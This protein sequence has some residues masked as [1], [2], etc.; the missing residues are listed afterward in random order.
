M[1]EQNLA[2]RTDVEIAVDGVNVTRKLRPYFL[3]L[4]YTDCEDGEADDLQL[5]LQDREGLWTGGWLDSMIQAAAS[6]KGLKLKAALVQRDWTGWGDRWL[7][8]GTFDLDSVEVS[9]PP[10]LVLLKATALPFS[11][12]IRQ[13]QKSRAWE[14]CSLSAIA[15]EMARAAGLGCLYDAKTDPK[16][17]RQEQRR[18]SDI[19]FLSRLCRD[20]GLSLKAT[21]GKLVVFDQSVYEKKPPVRTIR[22]GR[23]YIRCQLATGTA[24][25]QYASCRVR[26]T[27]PSTGRSIEGVAR[28]E[29][30][31]GEAKNNQQLEVS[32]KVSSQGQA[33]ALAASRLR[34]HNTFSRT[35]SFVFPG[36]PV[37]LAG[38]T[39]ELE[40]WG[41][42]D[43]KYMIAQAVH[44]VDGD[45]YTTKIELRRCLG[46]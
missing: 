46:S 30:Y 11:G 24:G 14:N 2:R 20:A 15:R 22:R 43:G 37:L 26:Y 1:T 3:S 45:G 16:Y 10:A 19:A 40:G 21:D 28:S 17:D 8:C 6:A 13:T 32:A 42:F 12:Q 31:D 23:D 41:A 34:L 33:E 38:S 5:A 7:T 18:Q 4:Q 9:G 27:D 29:D 36:D 25:T 44:T 39:V 35:G